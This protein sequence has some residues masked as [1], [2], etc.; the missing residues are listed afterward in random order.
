MSMVDGFPV[1]ANCD[2]RQFRHVSGMVLDLFEKE[3]GLDT[4]FGLIRSALS[5]RLYGTAYAFAC[6]VAAAEGRL[7]EDELIFPRDIRFAISVD[8]LATAAIE[9][10]VRVRHLTP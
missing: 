10:G 7:G 6:E 4:L 2:P 8:R 5:G 9:C 1:F 3:D